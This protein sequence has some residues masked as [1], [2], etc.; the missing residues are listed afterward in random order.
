HLS[1]VDQGPRG[2]NY[3][4]PTETVNMPIA[5]DELASLPSSDTVVIACLNEEDHIQGVIYHFA[6]ESERVVR[7]IVVADGGSTDRTIK[8]VEERSR[9]DG[10]IVLLHNTRQIQSSGINRAVE[11]YGDLAPFIIRVDAHADYP[12]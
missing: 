9:Q 4:Q 8:I 5:S 12:A 1:S 3:L 10:R 6:A 11:Q 7:K 2:T